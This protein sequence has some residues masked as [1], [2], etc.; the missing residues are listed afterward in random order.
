MPGTEYRCAVCGAVKR[1][2]AAMRGHVAG[3]METNDKSGG[4]HPHWRELAV[5]HDDLSAWAESVPAITDY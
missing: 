4:E 2:E 3:M 1:T 5:S